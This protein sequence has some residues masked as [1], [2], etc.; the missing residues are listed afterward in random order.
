MAPSV[1]FG[2]WILDFGFWILDC[3]RSYQSV[4]KCIIYVRPQHLLPFT[5]YVLRSRVT[6]GRRLRQPGAEAVSEADCLVDSQPHLER[7]QPRQCQRLAAEHQRL[8]QALG[9]RGLPI[10]QLAPA[11]QHMPLDPAPALAEDA[12]VA[13]A[14]EVAEDLAVAGDGRGN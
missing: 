7:R 8:E 14:R 13:A 3:A 10:G 4:F 5:F 1:N 2:F 11:R 12:D 6:V 9:A